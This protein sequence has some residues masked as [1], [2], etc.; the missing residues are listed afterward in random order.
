MLYSRRY[1]DYTTITCLEWNPILENDR[2]KDIIINSL[3]YLTNEE[4]VV[5]YGFVIMQ[6]HFHLLW[7]IMGEHELDEVQR[8]FLKYTGQQI[9][10][11]FRNEASS[12]LKDL[13]V[14]AKDRKYQVW[15]RNSLSIPL[16][17]PKVLIQK[18]EYIHNNPIRAGLCRY[19]EEY[20][21]SSARFYL[22]NEKD[23]DFLQHYDG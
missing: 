8:D 22:C 21:Y 9:L 5:V 4:R 23:W 15:E 10:K 6:N 19:P 16:W 2:N 12:I 17:T 1:P 11:I 3:R 7:Q 13:L 14:E 20:K 18:L